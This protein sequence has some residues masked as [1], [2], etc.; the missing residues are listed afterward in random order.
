MPAFDRFSR[1]AYDMQFIEERTFSVL[2]FADAKGQ[3]YLEK[4]FCRKVEMDRVR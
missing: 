2:T 3:S 1:K 4:S